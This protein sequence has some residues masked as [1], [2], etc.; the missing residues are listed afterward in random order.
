MTP[1]IFL[2]SI[3]VLL[4]KFPFPQGRCPAHRGEAEYDRDSYAPVDF[5][6]HGIEKKGASC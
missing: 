2:L 1:V 3:T 5:S 4:K 6:I